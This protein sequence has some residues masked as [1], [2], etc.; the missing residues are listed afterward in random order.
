MSHYGYFALA[1]NNNMNNYI[2]NTVQDGMFYDVETNK[3]YAIDEYNKLDWW[4]MY[5]AGEISL[6]T[7]QKALADYV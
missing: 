5:V 1:K 7:L 2:V 4:T 3:W 6:T